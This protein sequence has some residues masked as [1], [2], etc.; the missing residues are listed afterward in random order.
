MA[1]TQA[2]P[3]A[4]FVSAFF[5]GLMR[6]ARTRTQRPQK[7]SRLKILAKLGISLAIVAVFGLIIKDVYKKGVHLHELYL[8]A[9]LIPI[10]AIVPVNNLLLRRPWSSTG[11]LFLLASTLI[12]VAMMMGAGQTHFILDQIKTGKADGRIATIVS[13]NDTSRGYLLMM[14]EHRLLIYFPDNDRLSLQ[15]TEEIQRIEWQR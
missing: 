1:A 15:K 3:T 8:W 5:A 13:K 2:L 4:L 9:A 7:S 14:G 6:I 12:F 10:F 11:M